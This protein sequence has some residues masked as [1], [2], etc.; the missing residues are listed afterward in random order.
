[1]IEEARAF[2]ESEMKQWREWKENREQKQREEQERRDQ[3]RRE[4]REAEKAK[5][6]PRVQKALSILDGTIKKV[7]RD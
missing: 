5:Q 6:D 4:L 1:V 2:V 3:E 7:V